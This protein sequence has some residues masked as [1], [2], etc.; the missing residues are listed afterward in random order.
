MHGFLCDLGFDGCFFSGFAYFS[1]P[2]RLSILEHDAL[3]S[4]VFIFPF[5]A[6]CM[7]FPIQPPPAPLRVPFLHYPFVGILYLY[8]L[9]PTDLLPLVS[10][11]L[12]VQYTSHVIYF[13]PHPHPRPDPLAPVTMPSGVEEYGTPCLGRSY[14]ERARPRAHRPPLWESSSP[15]SPSQFYRARH[16]LPGMKLRARILRSCTAQDSRSLFRTPT[17]AHT[18]TFPTE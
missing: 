6:S 13:R 7:P 16:W 5:L 1:S 4:L 10:A 11:Y 8:A 14:R 9:Y 12:R 2:A 17:R 3:A 18:K 15:M